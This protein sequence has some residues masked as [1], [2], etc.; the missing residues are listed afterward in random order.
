M[1]VYDSIMQCDVHHSVNVYWFLGC[2]ICTAMHNA[3]CML[4]TGYHY[5]L[6]HWMPMSDRIHE[7]LV[8]MLLIDYT[9]CIVHNN[10]IIKYSQLYKVLSAG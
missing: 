10:I 6:W 1:Y 3:V 5:I 8:R 9:T 7:R 2:E 4:H